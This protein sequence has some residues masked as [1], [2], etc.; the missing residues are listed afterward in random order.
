[1]EQQF[2]TDQLFMLE[3][4]REARRSALL[5]EVP[6]GA[7]IVHDGAIIARGGNRRETAQDPTAHAELIAIRD[8]ASALGSWRL[9]DCTLYVTLEPCAMCAGACINARVSRIV[10]GAFDKKAGCCGSVAD[11]TALN[12]GAEPDVFAG[13]LEEE[14]VSLLTRF[15]DGRRRGPNG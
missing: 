9:C 10:F 12:L 2:S 5:D 13:I 1:M 6:V 11:L 3:A 15:F 8:A 7:V 4:L 14:C